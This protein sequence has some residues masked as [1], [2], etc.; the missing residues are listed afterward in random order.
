MRLFYELA[1]KLLISPVLSF[2]GGYPSKP[3]LRSLGPGSFNRDRREKL[4]S[5]H[6]CANVGAKNCFEKASMR[7]H[8]LQLKY[9]SKYQSIN[10]SLLLVE[11]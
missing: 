8:I 9:K 2:A 7:A 11:D 4:S 6:Q 5:A 1:L 3:Y 10:N